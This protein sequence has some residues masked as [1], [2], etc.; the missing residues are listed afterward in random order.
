MS[1]NPRDKS[2]ISG[3]YAAVDAAML[4][5]RRAK[6]LSSQSKLAAQTTP[7]A[8]EIEEIAEQIG[9]AAEI[10]CAHVF[11]DEELADSLLSEGVKI[12][13]SIENLSDN[14][15]AELQAEG[16]LDANVMTM[17]KE[18]LA[19][20]ISTIVPPFFPNE[21]EVDMGDL[22]QTIV[23]PPSE[24]LALAEISKDSRLIACF[25]HDQL[26]NP[27]ITASEWLNSEQIRITKKYATVRN[28]IPI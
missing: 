28:T 25:N 17:R 19:D 8:K 21:M 27:E 15:I 14:L 26:S 3:E 10:S 13:S 12:P 18:N 5:E 16:S 23:I 20:L 6:R 4:E 7:I 2:K 11:V 22:D 9:E 24:L 1:I